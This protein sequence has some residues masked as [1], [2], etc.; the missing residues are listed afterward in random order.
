M[1][2]LTIMSYGT[3][4]PPPRLEGEG[5]AMKLYFSLYISDSLRSLHV[6]FPQCLLP[7]P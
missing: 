2:D 6:W 4:S 7:A 1:Y 3:L 5:K